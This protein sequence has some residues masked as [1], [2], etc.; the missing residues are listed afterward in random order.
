MCVCVCDGSIVCT[1]DGSIVCTGQDL[2]DEV[3]LVDVMEDK[4]KGE[5]M[6]LQHGGLFLRTPKIVASKGEKVHAV[7]EC[8][9]GSS[10]VQF[11]LCTCIRFIE[12]ID[13]VSP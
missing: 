11:P 9:W 10:W 4:L 1:C 5:A 12:G 8:P 3:A 2:A 13:T 7:R 6:D